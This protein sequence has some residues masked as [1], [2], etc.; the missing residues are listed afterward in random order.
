[1]TVRHTILTKLKAFVFGQCAVSR[2]AVQAYECRKLCIAAVHWL[3]MTVIGTCTVRCGQSGSKRL[4]ELMG[5]LYGPLRTRCQPSCV[6]LWYPW[7]HFSL[8]AS[9]SLFWKGS[10]G[11]FLLIGE[12]NLSLCT[13]YLEVLK[14]VPASSFLRGLKKLELKLWPRQQGTPFVTKQKDFVMASVTFWPLQATCSQCQPSSVSLYSTHGDTFY[15][16]QAEAFSG[17]DLTKDFLLSGEELCVTRNWTGFLEVQ[18]WWLPASLSSCI[19][20]A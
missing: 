2:M 1:M 4:T 17:K 16:L 11:G 19:E 9:R 18:N 7:W 3:Q 5:T 14:E 15:C 12:E 20:R 13:C 6:V 8:S 10:A